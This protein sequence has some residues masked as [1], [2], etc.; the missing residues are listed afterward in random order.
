[1]Q[2]AF[3]GGIDPSLTVFKLELASGLDEIAREART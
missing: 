2:R 3:S 1:M